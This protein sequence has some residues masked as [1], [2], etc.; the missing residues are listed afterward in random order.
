MH[1][2]Q[3]F[4]Q[5]PLIYETSDTKAV[6]LTHLGVHHRLIISETVDLSEFVM[7]LEREVAKLLVS[8]FLIR[9]NKKFRKDFLSN[10]IK[11]VGE[12]VEM[13]FYRKLVSVYNAYEE[14]GSTHYVDFEDSIVSAIA[15]IASNFIHQAMQIRYGYM[16]QNKIDMWKIIKKGFD[17]KLLSFDK[18]QY[19][20][21]AIILCKGLK[22]RF[23]EEK[24]LSGKLKLHFDNEIDGTHS[25]SYSQFSKITQTPKVLP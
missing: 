4:Y 14:L 15:S 13:A 20:I 12:D 19:E 8:L 16:G 6:E 11:F 24:V 5:I 23:Y 1:N 10:K 2:P 7:T 3:L 18:K 21:Q 25:I 17:G 22:K 9:S